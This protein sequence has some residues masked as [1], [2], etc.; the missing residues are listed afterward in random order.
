MV[1]LRSPSEYARIGKTNI[2]FIAFAIR[3]K[4]NQHKQILKELEVGGAHGHVGCPRICLPM[5]I[6]F[7]SLIYDCKLY[8]F[9]VKLQSTETMVEK[10]EMK[11]QVLLHWL[12]SIA[13]ILSSTASNLSSRILR[14]RSSLLKR[15]SSPC[16]PRYFCSCTLSCWPSYAGLGC[17]RLDCLPTSN[18]QD[19]T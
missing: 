18:S 14:R 9:Q 6:V 2:G 16:L 3:I 11:C 10:Y 17:M 1:L 7:Q 5:Y 19:H 13:F 15:A 4:P 8:V 12:I